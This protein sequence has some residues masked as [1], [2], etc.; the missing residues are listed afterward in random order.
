MP[1]TQGDGPR[2]IPARSLRLHPFKGERQ[3]EWAV[4][5]SRMLRITFRFEDGDV[6]DVDLTDYH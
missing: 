6:R 2:D 3:G 5:V 1:W 4:D